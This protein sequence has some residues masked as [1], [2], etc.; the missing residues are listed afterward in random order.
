MHNIVDIYTRHAHFVE[1]YKTGQF[2]KFLPFLARVRRDLR[3][4]LLKTNTVTSQKAIKRKLK[5]IESMVLAHFR[6]FTKDFGDQLEL[7]AQSEVKFG[8]KSF[9]NDF[10]AATPMLS[11]LMAAINSRPFNNKLLRDALND[12]GKTQARM[13]RDAVSMGFFESKTT[14]EIINDVI[15]TAKNKFRDGTMNISRNAASRLVRTSINHVS[16]VAKDAL[17]KENIDLIT[18]YEWISTLDSRTSD[19]C[20]EL[21]GN[22]YRVGKGRLPPAHPNCRSTTSPVLKG[23]P[24]IKDSL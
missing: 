18:H 1:R 17:Y 15:G 6:E 12:F 11:R 23:D 20:K 21:D 2:N 19:I 3:N 16:A 8:V 13:I 9:G 24:R 10:D 14:P 7:F 5:A 4:E 22:I